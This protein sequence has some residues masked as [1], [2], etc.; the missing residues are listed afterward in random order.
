MWR[1]YLTI[2]IRM[3]SKERSYAIINVVGLALGL[4]ACLALLLYV[5]Y[6]RSYDTWLPGHEDVYQLQ[7]VYTDSQT[8]EAQ[9][10]QMTQYPAA[11]A[12]RQASPDFAAGVFAL[13][14]MPTVLRGSE[15][16]AIERGLLVDGDLLDVLRLPLVA[17]DPRTA[18]RQGGAVL[19]SATEAR[20]IFGSANP[21][22][23]TVTLVEKGVRRDRPVTG[24]YRDL[25]RNSSLRF[26][27]VQRFDPGT[28]FA[29]EPQW[30]TSYDNLNG[31]FFARLRA[32]A[33]PE[34]VHGA[35]LRW[36]DRNVPP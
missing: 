30:L 22:G 4:A 28:Y 2:A 14:S 15:A 17:G 29:D 36:R 7:T 18:L 31:W 11:A 32:G 12:L 16:L 3:L 5:R 19:L 1:N 13:T 35:L 27:L 21:V 8:G 6:E 33:D 34:G 9:A 10:L 24:V 26:G 23:R 25:P 20:R